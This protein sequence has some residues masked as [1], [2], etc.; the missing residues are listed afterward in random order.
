MSGTERYAWASLLVWLTALAFLFAKFTTGIEVFGS[1]LGLTIVEL[2]AAK[3]LGT[4]VSLTIFV[5]VLESIV[6][7]VTATVGQTGRVDKDERDDR[8]NARANLA[9]Y[10]FVAAALNIIVMH[11]LASAAFGGPWNRQFNLSSTSGIASSTR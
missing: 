1:S 8:I 11:V 2:P 7:S 6:A 3:L 9:A 5:I 4:Y 10:W